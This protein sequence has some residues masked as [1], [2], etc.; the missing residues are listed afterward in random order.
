MNTP[1]SDLASRLAEAQRLEDDDQALQA[2]LL[3][4]GV[5]AEHAAA[6]EASRG[7]ARLALRRGDVARALEHLERAVRLDP[8]H[9]RLAIDLALVLVEARQPQAAV[10]ALQVLLE[11]TPGHGPAWLLLRQLRGQLGDDAGALR[12]AYEAATHAVTIPPQLAE[13]VREAR[14]HVRR[15]RRELFLDSYSDLRERYGAHELRRVDKAVDGYL[16]RHE[17]GE[18]AP[19]Q[20]ATF[21]HFPDLPNTPY[22]D[23]T[24]QPW[25]ERLRAAFPQIRAEAER[26][27]AEDRALPSFVD[28]PEGRTMGD[29]VDGAG[30][31][32]SWEALFFYRQ[33][34][35]YDENHARCPQTS[36]LLESIDLC[37]IDAQAPEILFS[38]LRPGSHI[39][40]HY[41]VSNIRLV[42]HLPLIVPPDCAL[43]LVGNG[44]HAW[45]EGELVMFDDTY[46]HEAWNRSERTRVV[47]LMDCW[48]PH[49][50]MIERRAL[51][52]LIAV[53]TGLT[54]I[55]QQHRDP[56]GAS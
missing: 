53:T 14:D 17:T 49:L 52:Q 4:V 15:H 6:S 3:Y 51:R 56:D 54:R 28:V 20:R 27:I 40:A 1:G 48:N 36:A 9:P 7:I 33:G 23:V 35:R 41:G 18:T 31:A 26:V 34:R 55:A 25:A 46:L 44:E 50:S 43:N 37:R 21:M 24:L 2:E 13:L 42:M 16:R 11:H 47:L 39:K 5:L 12:A 10:A 19:G 32:P 22:H 29:Y 8:A 45:R 38:V 30:D